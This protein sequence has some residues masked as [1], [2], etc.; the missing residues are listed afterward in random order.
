MIVILSSCHAHSIDLP[1]SYQS[2]II[3]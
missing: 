1:V 3:L 2:M